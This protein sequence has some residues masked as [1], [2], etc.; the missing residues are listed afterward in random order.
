MVRHPADK[1]D[2]FTARVHA[3]LR[4]FGWYNNDG[5]R[6]TSDRDRGHRPGLSEGQ[7]VDE[8]VRRDWQREALDELTRLSQ[9]LPGGY[10]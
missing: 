1:P 3:L 5:F 6:E 9:E 2:T 10:R 7:A 4:E 8:M